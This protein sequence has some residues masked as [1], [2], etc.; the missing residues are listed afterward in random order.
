[1]QAH[2]ATNHSI[3]EDQRPEFNAFHATLLISTLNCVVQLSLCLSISCRRKI[4]MKE[5]EIL[6][7]HSPSA[8]DPGRMTSDSGELGRLT[9]CRTKNARRRRMEIRRLNITCQ[10]MM[11]I[12]ITENSSSN[13]DKD[14]DLLHGSKPGNGLTEISLSLSS[15]SSKQSSS[16]END[17]VLAG[18][19]EKTCEENDDAQTLSCTSHGLLSVIGRR[20]EMEDAVKV[21]LGF[22][23]KGRENFDFYGVYD[24]HG[25][26]R[27]AQE[28]KERL[29]KVLVEEIVGD[30]YKEENGIDWGRT[31]ERCFEKMDDEVNRGRLGEEMVGST[32]VVAVVGNGKLVVANCGDSRAVLS[33]GGVAVALSCDHK[34]DRSDELERV[35]AA[36][37]RVINWN[38]HRVLGVLATS[39]S[40]GTQKYL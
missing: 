37:G 15:P 35:E 4:K 34:P 10:T 14:K 22:M 3:A 31:M 8:K 30:N 19:G 21:E 28:C 1:M 33:K 16:E 5:E 32:A 20:R 39:R 24:G 18:F 25:G 40:I 7:L 36:G 6:R 11:N 26:S 2:V 17:I 12:T 38:G 13:G 27:V 23:V 9:I 29:H